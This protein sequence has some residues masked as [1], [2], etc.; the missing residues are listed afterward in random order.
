MS[1]T[2]TVLI[3]ILKHSKT[4]YRDAFSY[5]NF[6]TLKRHFFNQFKGGD[7]SSIFD[8]PWKHFHYTQCPGIFRSILG[9]SINDNANI[10]VSVRH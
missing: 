8:E 3:H 6:E 1:N 2:N 7:I 10:Q 5:L 9:S 4:S